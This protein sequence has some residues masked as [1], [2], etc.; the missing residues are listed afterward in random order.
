M[1]KII[2][3]IKM[4][5]DRVSKACLTSIISH[6]CTYNKWQGEFFVV[7]EESK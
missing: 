3:N 5:Y 2:L 7:K 1:F 6:V 4:L